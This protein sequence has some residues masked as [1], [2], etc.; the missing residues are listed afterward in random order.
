MQALLFISCGAILGASLRWT[1]GLLFNPLFSSFAFG[2]LIANLL[3]CLIIGVLLGIF[4]Q[5]PQISS[6]WRLFLIT[7]FL[8]SLTTFSS[9]F[10][11]SCGII[12]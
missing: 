8:G 9:F 2:T 1:I 5:F 6:E 3:G 12:F 11:R 4:W 7:G 10:F